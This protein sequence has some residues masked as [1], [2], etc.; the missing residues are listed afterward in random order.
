MAREQLIERG[1]P[2]H[3][4]DYRVRKG[5]LTCLHRGVYRVGPVG[6]LRE[7]EMA[8][9]LACGPGSFISHRSAAA[10]WGL[11]PAPREGDPVDVT[12]QCGRRRPGCAIRVHRAPPVPTDEITRRE[13][14]RIATPARSL[15]DLASCAGTREMERALA[16][17]EREDLVSL[18]KV[19]KLVALYPRRRGIGRL[20]A[21]VTGARRPK[22]T[23]SEAEAIFLELLR[24]AQ[25]RPPKT[26]RVVRGFEVDFV[27]PMENLVVEIDGWTFHRSEAAF[28]QDR[29]RDGIMAAAGVRVVRV[30]WQQPP[31]W[32]G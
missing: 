4:I 32:R 30:T 5:I 19:R 31:S 29:R 13:G 11:V 28:E 12:I 15:L 23:R 22:L 21:L 8:A 27:W 10:I 20:R 17:A 6:G 2:R 25:L 24:E 7:R 18:R 3:W 9:T 1:L 16:R 26:N 14:L